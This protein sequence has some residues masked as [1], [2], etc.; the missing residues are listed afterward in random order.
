MERGNSVLQSEPGCLAGEGGA[1]RGAG[2]SGRDV[3][4]VH[5]TVSGNARDSG[6]ARAPQKAECA[7]ER[8][9]LHERIGEACG[10]RSISEI[11]RL[12]RTNHETTRRYVRGLSRPTTKFL[13]AVCQFSGVTAEWLLCG[14]G[15]KLQADADGEVVKRSSTRALVAELTSR[16]DAH[17]RV[18]TDPG[19][20]SSTM[21]DIDAK[22]V[23]L[24]RQCLAVSEFESKG[25]VG[26]KARVRRPG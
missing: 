1:A 4:I 20:S 3:V 26:R 13:S 18:S 8:T 22:L 25:S 15:P 7:P 19:A 14:L 16:M 6:A 17:L 12:T 5:A 2:L 24:L 9:H 11:S 23:S 10:D 21:I